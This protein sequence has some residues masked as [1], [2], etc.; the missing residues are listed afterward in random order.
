MAPQAQ[1]SS[2]DWNLQSHEPKTPFIYKLS[3]IFCYSNGSCP[4]QKIG[5]DNGVI[6]TV[7][8]YLMM[9][10]KFWI[11]IGGLLKEFGKAQRSRLRESRMW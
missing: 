6:S 11:G 4:T 7:T 1:K 5:T 9:R 10:R 3:Q 2:M 8:I